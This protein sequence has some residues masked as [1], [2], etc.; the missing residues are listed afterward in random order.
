[1]NGIRKFDELDIE[2]IFLIECFKR[3]GLQLK[4]IKEYIEWVKIDDSTIQ[5]RY[6]F[7]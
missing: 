7:F 3:S 6:D 4:E 5:K 2:M 1:M